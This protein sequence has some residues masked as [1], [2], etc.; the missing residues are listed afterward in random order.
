MTRILDKQPDLLTAARVMREQGMAY[1]DIALRL[2]VGENTVARWLGPGD[3]SK[4]KPAKKH[5][6][7]YVSSRRGGQ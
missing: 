6:V 2:G 7:H 4:C 1:F 5:S 3:R